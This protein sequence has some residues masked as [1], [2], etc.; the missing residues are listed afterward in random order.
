M[1]G[2]GIKEDAIITDIQY[3]Y[4]GKIYRKYKKLNDICKNMTAT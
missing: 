4:S 1:E 3:I 2:Y